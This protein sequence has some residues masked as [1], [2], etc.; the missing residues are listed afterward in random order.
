MLDPANVRALKR[1]GVVFFIDRRPELLEP[2]ADRPL[3]RDR[4]ALERLYAQR[5]PAYIAAADARIPNDGDLTDTVESII[6]HAQ[7]G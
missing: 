1:N 3:S 2:T 5:M 7:Q 6:S 4:S